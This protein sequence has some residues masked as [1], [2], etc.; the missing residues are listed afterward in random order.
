[1]ALSNANA[2]VVVA[3]LLPVIAFWGYCLLDFTRTD[4]SDLRMFSRPVWLLILLFTSIFGSLI[5][6]Y[7]GRAQRP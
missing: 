6:W 2:I 5:W 3:V 7:Y 1:M 4:E